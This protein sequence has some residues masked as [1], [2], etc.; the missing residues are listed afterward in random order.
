M[1]AAPFANR[2]MPLKTRLT[3]RY[4][5][6]LSLIAIV[7]VGAWFILQQ[8]LK[9]NELDASLI[10]TAGQQRMLSQRIAL[11]SDELVA[12]VDASERARLAGALQD[13]IDRMRRNHASLA[14]DAGAWARTPG[15]Q[16][17]Y[18]GPE[19]LDAR[20]RAYTRQAQDFLDAVRR[21]EAVAA[22]PGALT[23]TAVHSLLQPLDRVVGMYQRESEAKL[24]SFRRL[25]TTVL[26]IGLAVLALEALLIFRP[27]VRRI[28]RTVRSLEQVNTE[29]RE[30]SV[31]I[32]HDLRAPIASAAGLVGIARDATDNGDADMARDSLGR[33]DNALKSLDRLIGD[34]IDVARGGE[35]GPSE[36]VDLAALID[37]IIERLSGMPGGDRVDVIAEVALAA[38]V[39][40]R[41][42]ELRQ[43]V[44]NLVSNAI[45]YTDAESPRVAIQA[46]ERDGDVVVAVRDNGRGIDPRHRGELFG[47][48]KRFHRERAPGSG[49]GLYLS[50]KL[51]RSL[52]GD[53][54][55]NPLAPGSEF[56]L[57]LPVHG[58]TE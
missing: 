44:E 48:F 49:L 15:I 4:A 10:N 5:S 55:Y 7:L 9:R 42:T 21:D 1:A 18:D 51:A 40:T 20:V 22:H 17:H 6:A 14:G 3:L 38:P 54:S 12:S 39:L 58:G 19:G 23:D 24:A 25:E 35:P 56:S 27:M 47:M 30:F 41:R 28:D 11:L 45:K 36:P 52:G 34:I 29:L 50:R 16:A 53:L 46:L 57:T 31:R 13:A 33:V 43:I 8:Q 32:S 37:D 2:I 26:A